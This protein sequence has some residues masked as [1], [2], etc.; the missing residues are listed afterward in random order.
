MKNIFNNKYFIA[1]IIL[2]AG[3]AI[4]YLISSPDKPQVTEQSEHELADHAAEEIWTCSMHPQIR[5]PEPG[6][7]PICGMD[8][9][10]ATSKSSS[11]SQDPVVYEMT[12]EAVAMANISTSI[13]TGVSPDGEVLLSGKIQADERNIATITAQYP[14]RIEQLFVNFTGQVVRRGERLA[15]IYSPELLTAQRELLEAASTKESFPELYEAAREKLRLWK[16][17]EAQIKQIEESG[18]VKSEFNVIADKGGVVMQR[19]ISVGD[20]VNT[21]SILFEV[22]DLSRVWIM[23]DAY[24]SDLSL[25][26]RG[27]KVSFTVAGIAGKTYEATVDFIDPIIDQNTRSAS[28]RAEVANP[29]MEL[30]PG[31]FVKAR[32][33]SSSQKA[34]Q[35]LA[36][37]RTALLWTGKRSIVYVKVPDTE[38]PAYE[39]RE[40]TIGTRMGDMWLVES[41]LEAG[42]EIVT[43]GAFSV[44]AAA[45]LAG[46]YS[47]MTRPK[48]KTMEVPEKFREQI[49]EIAEEYFE[50]K[51]KLVENDAEAAR[52]QFSDI[53]E[54]VNQVEMESLEKNTHDHWMQLKRDMLSA[55]E[56]MEAAKGIE[57]QRQHFV[58]L[59]DQVLEMTELFGLQ[60]D[61]VYKQH[62]PM[63]F[64]NEG[65]Y[66]LSEQ[67]EILNP[68]FG[69]VMLTCGEVTQTY[70]K[71]QRVFE[72][73][74]E[75]KQQPTG[76]QH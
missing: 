4:G 36:I 8:L 18:K 68:Y 10:P 44:D 63:A 74:D 11:A 13:V 2:I 58:M 64:D 3:I 35:S 37:P 26:N 65:A 9:I 60:K 70:R 40:I 28:V 72:K 61:K 29:D 67:E 5:L 69:D 66:W 22:V 47:M 57:E 34:K 76:H 12:P 45:Q 17:S 23:L 59:S 19:N 46:N 41:G 43:N 7:C 6:D 73:E 32:I 56:M 42:E 25:I 38:F 75:V 51:N 15:T 21:G 49:T 48:A 54:A 27:D 50:L 53:R 20:Y 62:C 33:Q 71:G 16:L 55:I 52:M 1:V 14:G 31:M 24:E 39:M 30:K